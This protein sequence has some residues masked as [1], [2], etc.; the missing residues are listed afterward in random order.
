MKGVRIFNGKQYHLKA[1]CYSAKQRDKNIQY[2]RDKGY[3]VRVT[4]QKIRRYKDVPGTM[5][6]YNLWARR[7]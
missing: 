5:T 6:R 2:F 7:K 1:T 4:K 3:L